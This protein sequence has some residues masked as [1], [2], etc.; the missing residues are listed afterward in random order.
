M[1]DILQ[2]NDMLVPELIDLAD[3]LSI[4]H[5]KKSAK[6]ELIHKILDKQALTA[7]ESTQANGEKPKRKRIIKAT[8]VAIAIAS[9]PIMPEEQPVATPETIVHAEEDKEE[10]LKKKIRKPREKGH[11]AP[12]QEKIVPER[13]PIEIDIPGLGCVPDDVETIRKNPLMK[14]TILLMK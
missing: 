2:L 4:P 3:Q 9:E 1:Y 6:Q 12:E 7:V 10:K 5:A 8:P 14:K 13:E 11:E